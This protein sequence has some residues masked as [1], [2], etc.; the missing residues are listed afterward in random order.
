MNA[1]TVEQHV[2]K[3]DAAIFGAWSDDE[4]K[5][6]RYVG[7]IERVGTIESWIKRV[8]IYGGAM[9]VVLVL[10]ALGVPT[11]KVFSLVSALIGLL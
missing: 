3:I 11:D 5:P 4:K 6:V 1:E 8:A 2:N 10:H 9:L 7:L